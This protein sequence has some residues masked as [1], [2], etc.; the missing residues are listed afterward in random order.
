MS[1]KNYSNAEK[2]FAIPLMV[3]STCITEFLTG[4]Q[5]YVISSYVVLIIEFLNN[6]LS[7][8]PFY[9]DFFWLID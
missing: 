1:A 5:S 3:H 4:D 6:N 7:T 9:I 2:T 8:H